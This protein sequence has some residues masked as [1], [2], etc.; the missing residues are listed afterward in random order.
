[1]ILASAGLAGA[2]ALW[3]FA[4]RTPPIPR[5]TLRIG[6]EHVP[7]VQIR[8]DSGFTGLAV[9][10]VSEAA[11]RAGLSLQWVE[12]G[13][14]S[15]EALR[16]GL[17]DLWPIM[18]DLP[19]RRKHVHM[20][21]PWLHTGHVLVLPAASATPDRR[22]A[23]NIALFKL[24]IHVRLVREA[25][26]EAHL[27]QFPDPRE[28]MRAVCRGTVAA[29]FLEDRAAL[30]ALREKPAECG[31]MALRAWTIPGLTLQLGTGSTFPAA[32]AADKIRD[33]IGGLFRDGTLAGKVAKY[34][35][36][37]LDDTWTTYDLLEA[38]ERARWLAWGIA[39]LGIVL[40]VTLWQAA[41]L[42]QR[43][44]SEAALRESEQRFRAIFSQAAVGITQTSLDGV[45][46]AVNH[47]AC[48]MLGYS[49]TEMRGKPFLEVTHPDD[50][51]KSGDAMRRLLA[52]EIS[53]WQAEKR[54]I[55]KDGGI[56]WTRVSVS[57]VRD[58]NN[59]PQYFISAAED[60]T[61]RVRAEHARQYSERRLTLAESAAHVGL[62]ECDLRTKT[63]TTSAE[64]ARQRG[65]P[66]DTPPL[67]YKEWLG[68]VHA[69]DRERVH[70]RMRESIEKRQGWDAEF[71]VVWPDGSIHWLLTKGTVFVDDR[72]QAVGLAGVNLDIT[73]RKRAE[74]ALRESEENFRAIFHQAAVGVAQLSLGGKVEL[75]NDC[76]CRVIGC[77]QKDLLGKGTGEF[78]HGKDL[79]A[80]LPMLRQ[81]LAG[82]IQSYS[83]EKRY[84]RKDGSV[85]WAKT[86]KSLARD[87]DNQPKHI[88]AIMEDITE[89]KRAEEALRENEQCLVSIYNT[90]GDAIFRLA[91][92][93]EGQFRFVSV[94]AAFLRVTGLSLEKV[95]GK[96]VNEVIPEPSLTM[97]LGK[98]RQA[99]EEN[100]TVLWEETSDYPSGRM[101][102]EVRVA[103]VYDNKGTCTHLVGSV[104]DITER[105]RAEAALRASEE[106][107]RN[108]ADTAPVMIWVSGPD[109]LCTFFNRGWLAFTGGTLEQAAGNGWTEKVHP[110][111]RGRCYTSYSLAFDAHRAFQTEC[112]LRR[113]DG[114]YR[115][116][117]ATGAPRFESSGA[118]VGYVGSCT[119][120]TDLKHTQEE[121]LARHKLESL[122]VL[123][124][125][126]AHD[127][128]NLLGSIVANS[129]LV[130]S[131]LPDG[132]PASEGVESIR[133]VASRAAEIVGQMMAY[134]GQEDTVFEPV[135]LSGLLHEMLEFLKVSISKR[136]T[137]N[138]TL[139][140]KLPTVRGNA[141]QL[142]QVLLNLITNA[143]EALG[144]QEGIISVAATQ[145]QSGSESAPNPAHG[146]YVRLEISDTGCGMTEEIQSRIF[147]PFFTTKFAGRG[148]GLAAVKGIVRSHGGVLNVVSVPGQ[149]SRFEILLPRS[150]ESARKGHDEAVSSA[151]AEVASF[152]GTVLV[153]EDEDTLRVAVS[154]MLRNKGF[155]VI[156]AADGKTGVDLF[157][158][159]AREIDVVLLDLTLPGMA[160]REVLSELR[161]VQPNV[162]VIVTSAYSQ[163]RALTTLGGQQPWLY[164]RKPYHLNELTGLLRNY[165]DKQR[166]SDHATG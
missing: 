20:T 138:V 72:G 81:L 152:A 7:P 52:G 83:M 137:L 128:N 56:V 76:Y 50:L 3:Y 104:H 71:R 116:M 60:M 105:R 15:E 140:E 68:F 11:K 141:A 164:I 40:S 99:V 21:R 66:P 49:E 161:R 57:L 145:V 34:S 27:V 143:S 61:D 70:A 26:P 118:F 98:Y 74:A 2:M 144:E 110:D 4:I 13:T 69:D 147:D 111:D 114:E 62:W 90:V 31:S 92:E 22:F 33:E 97:V 30:T 51:E 106:R 112:R 48:E 46:L 150:R 18:I 29:G 103:P 58:Q 80:Q 134:A 73:E 117:L 23:G 125:G 79:Q 1:L 166:V 45:L 88:I 96:M 47:R 146:D 100:T 162:N 155:T 25:F 16:R 91:V 86:C 39:G 121:A 35:Y 156:E 38:A 55:H 126:V 89:K 108:M 124:G 136:A 63:I 6:F 102:G 127:F 101:T 142:R 19:D 153:V 123:A 78:T 130:L 42:R 159:S 158:A 9:E 59:L 157:R 67:R 5:R 135:D 149:G 43:K 107:F 148:M 165:L 36:Y 120:I 133:N 17:V 65:L 53:S 93:P 75:A 8:T 119:D 32:G 154:K 84:E 82:E 85:V 163:E 77:V 12:T 24:P 14:S 41:S 37:G 160:G 87:G 44:R 10:I 113:S 139:R 115:W 64:F 109:K 95:V 28:V 131:E 132:S 54:F 122:G 129:E 94:N 151:A